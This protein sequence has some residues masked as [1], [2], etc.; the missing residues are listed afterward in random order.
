M[1]CKICLED[2]ETRKV[3]GYDTCLECYIEGDSNPVGLIDKLKLVEE[4]TGLKE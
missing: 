3:N 4:W 2:K 1:E